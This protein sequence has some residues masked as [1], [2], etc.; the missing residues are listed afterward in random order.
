[1]RLV[2]DLVLNHTSDEHPWFARALEDPRAPE[3][4]YYV[5]RGEDEP[6]P[7]FACIFP[8]VERGPWEFEEQG[9]QF[10]LHHFYRFQ[11]DLD[12][13]H[14]EVRRSMER[15]VRFW[16]E[17]GVS[18]LRIDA[19]SHIVDKTARFSDRDDDGHWVL[20]ELAET[21]RSGCREGALMAEADVPVDELEPYFGGGDEIQLL[22]NFP[23]SQHLWLA[24]ARREPSPL[25]RLV[26]SLPPT[27][28]G[29]CFA[30]FLRNHDE[31][32][33]ERLTDDERDEVLAAFA[34]QPVM[35]AYG[36]GIPAARARPCSAATT[37]CS[38]WPT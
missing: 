37:R 28:E 1:M 20:R 7:P 11:P 33:L 36:D 38:R 32:D 4:D 23:A 30:N 31:L 24:L 9:R 3:R 25:R 26:S 5:F 16:G 22:L 10:Y 35:R 12:P 2:L 8:G 18:G 19:A 14:P 34:P 6:R 27:P 17:L 29:S 21:I 13:C 15:I